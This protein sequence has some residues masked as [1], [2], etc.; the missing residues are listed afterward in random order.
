[1]SQ[2]QIGKRY[3]L[4]QGRINS[5]IYNRLPKYWYCHGCK[6]RLTRGV[7]CVFCKEKKLAAST[8]ARANRLK[9]RLGRKYLPKKCKTCQNLFTGAHRQVC[10]GCRRPKGLARRCVFCSCLTGSA[11]RVCLKC[12][13]SRGGS[14]RAQGRDSIRALVRARDSYK[15]QECGFI[16]TPETVK[17]YNEKIKTKK[18]KIKSLD[19]HHLN[20]LCGKRSKGYDKAENMPLLITL[21]HKCHFNR[22]DHSLRVVHP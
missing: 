17:T 20:G 18:G 3:D 16:R 7:S 22:H 5:I 6:G 14:P 10:E 12:C 13:P 15:C 1:M 9:E 8:I 4:T 19:V 2:A 11:W 21:C